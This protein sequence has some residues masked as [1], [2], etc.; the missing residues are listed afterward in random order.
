MGSFRSILSGWN[1]VGT[2]AIAFMCG[3]YFGV[4]GALA[5]LPLVLISVLVIFGIGMCVWL[6][7]QHSQ[8]ADSYSEASPFGDRALCYTCL[9]LIG[10]VAVTALGSAL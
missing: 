7:I 8:P 3:G 6:A 2:F 4:R 9:F 1:E 10:A 5:F